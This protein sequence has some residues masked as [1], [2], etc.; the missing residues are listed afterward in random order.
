MRRS[1]RKEL[2]D[3]IAHRE[4]LDKEFTRKWLREHA[5]NPEPKQK[6]K[7][8]PLERWQK[9]LRAQKQERRALA[10]PLLKGVE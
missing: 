7:P 9:R 2:D 3:Q 6:P 1:R 4:R 10:R 8:M 5:P